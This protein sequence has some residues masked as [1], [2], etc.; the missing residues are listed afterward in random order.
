MKTQIKYDLRGHWRLHK[1]IFLLNISL[2]LSIYL[3]I[4]YLSIYLHIIYL[5]RRGGYTWVQTCATL[6]CNTKNSEEQTIICVNYVLSGP[7]HPNI[8]MDSEQ[9]CLYLSIL[10]ASYLSILLASYLSINLSIYLSVCVF[11]FHPIFLVI[12]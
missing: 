10:L 8:L 11:I 4:I 1:V 3:S 9:V 7:Q 2:Y 5:S 6:V 12:Y